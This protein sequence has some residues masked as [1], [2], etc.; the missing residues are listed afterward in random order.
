LIAQKELTEAG[1]EG[2]RWYEDE[3]QP[4]EQTEHGLNNAINSAIESKKHKLNAPFNKY[5]TLANP[6]NGEDFLEEPV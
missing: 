4:G 5:L 6:R 1:D 2:Q 3:T